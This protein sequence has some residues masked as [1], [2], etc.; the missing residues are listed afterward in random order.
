MYVGIIVELEP[1]KFTYYFGKEGEGI[2]N[3]SG[4]FPTREQAEVALQTEFDQIEQQTPKADELE[5]L[6][7]NENEDTLQ[8]L[9]NLFE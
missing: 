3:P 2:P 8:I 4:T 7:E 9:K 1:A 6:K 5:Y